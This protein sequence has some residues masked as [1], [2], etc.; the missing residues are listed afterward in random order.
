[1]PLAYPAGTI[2]EHLACR[3]RRGRLRRQPPRHRAGRGRRA[4]SSALQAAAHQ[5]P[6][7]DRARA[8]RSTRTC[9]TPTT[10]RC[11]TTSSCGGVDDERLRR[12]AQRLQHRPGAG[13]HRG[14]RRHRGAGPSSPCRAPRPARRLEAVAPEAAAVG[15]FRVAAFDV[16]T[17]RRAP[18]P[19]PATRART[20]SRSPCRPR[21]RRRSGGAV[22][23]AGVDAGR[24]GRPRHAAAGGRPAA[25][26]P[27]AG[28]GHH[29]AAGRAGLGGVVD[30]ADVPGPGRARGRAGA[31]RA[32]G[33][34]GASP[35][36][37]GGRRGRSCA[38]LV[39][40]AGGRGR[41]PAA[42]S[43]PCSAT[44]SRWPSCRPTVEE[45]AAVEVDVRGSALPG[46]WSPPRSSARPDGGGRPDPSRFERL[47]AGPADRLRRGPDRQRPPTTWPRAFAP[48]DRLVVVQDDRRP[49]A[50]PAADHALADAG[51][52]P[53]PIGAF[54][55]LGRRPGRGDHRRSSRASPAGWRTTAVFA[56]IAAA[57]A[58]DVAAAREQGR[59][60]TRLV[61]SDR[62]RADMVAGLRTWRDMPSERDAAHRRRRAPGLAGRAAARAA[63]RGRVR[64]RGTPERLRRRHGR[65][66]GRQH[67]RLPHRPRRARHRHR[68]RRARARARRS[69]RPG[70][71]RARPRSSP[72]PSRATRLRAV[73]PSAPGPRG[74]PRLGPGRRP[75]RRGRP[76]GRRAG[77]PPRHRRRVARRRRRRRRRSLR[78][79]RSTTRST[80]R[81]ATRSTSVASSSDRAAGARPSL[82][83]RRWRPRA[84]GGRRPPSCTSPE[85]SEA[86]RAPGVVRAEGRACSGPSGPVARAAGRA[87]AVGRA[88]PRV[89]VGGAARR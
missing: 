53:R 84:S 26:R 30:Q 19:A 14:R 4:R 41:P 48:G 40:G 79:P 58:D 61:L 46:P 23:A 60:T 62:M 80:A 38:V 24:A 86:L 15:R 68:H 81:S 32:P 47:E 2:A 3:Q 55:E 25:A 69:P 13:R 27:R 72:S 83:R 35:P 11:S 42:T 75:A 82:P 44:A 29:P 31:R 77:Q 74:G 78:A 45:G 63:R 1:M 7:Q 76:P 50:V 20:A 71:R 43:R 70:C 34:C 85:G 8:G 36:R 33:C 10:P 67:G 17:A 65:A 51:G 66:A 56:P 73:L 88:R 54:L 28:P 22:L 57:N 12:D 21:R 59:S 52:R 5:R 37:A 39:D 18:S 87:A 6:G 89:G 49:A 9:S 16:A 64:V